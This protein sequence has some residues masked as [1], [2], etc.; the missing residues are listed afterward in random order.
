[1]PE[2]SNTSCP[3]TQQIVI[4]GRNEIEKKAVFFHPDCGQWDCPYCG[5]MKKAEWVHQAQRGSQI[6]ISGGNMMQFVTLTSKGGL[7]PG[8]SI[9]FFR[10][11][12]PKF[13]KRLSRITEKWSDITGTQFAYFV[14]PERHKSGVLHMHGLFTTF[15]DLKRWYKDTANE[16][17]FGYMADVQNVETSGEAVGYITKYIGKDFGGITWPKGFMRV[18]HS[19]TWPIANPAKDELWD[20]LAI[21]EK[22]VWIEKNALIDLGYYVIDRSED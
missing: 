11:N 13:R 8:K 4:M 5:E 2:N 10:Q 1:M 20:W 9:Y 12:F 16:C 17:G 18:R 14:V 7:T 21:Q 3:T 6:L 19:L 22:D 15:M